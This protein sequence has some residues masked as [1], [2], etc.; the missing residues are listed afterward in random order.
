MKK[1]SLKLLSYL[2][3]QNHINPNSCQ[4][5][6]S[7]VIENIIRGYSKFNLFK[8]SKDLKKGV[9]IYG[10]V[11]VGKSVLLKAL[12]T[13]YSSSEI[14]HFSDLI[15]H[16]QART[17]N[18]ATFL[19]KLKEKKLILIDE[20]SINNLTNF[21]LFQKFLENIKKLKIPLIMS[22]NKKLMK[23]YYLPLLI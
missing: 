9:Y 8:F 10:S 14:L 16:L 15:F 1:L 7:L 4:I 12:N 19:N 20:F 18:N 23:I 17:K 13:V 6:A 3:N 5:N 22:G 21:I 11:G 2:E